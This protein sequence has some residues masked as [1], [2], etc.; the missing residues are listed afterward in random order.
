MLNRN[1][2]KIWI[3][4]ISFIWLI[5]ILLSA[6]KRLAQFF[7]PAGSVL[8][9]DAQQTYLPAARG[10]LAAPWHFLTKDQLSYNV[11][12]LGY[13]WP[14]LWSADP[15]SN[16]IAN[17][18]LFL[19]CVFLM[20]Y[21]G[22][23]LAGWVAGMASSYL[24][25]FHPTIVYY[26]PHVLTES[27]YLF[28]LLVLITSAIEYAL[29]PRLRKVCAGFL[30]FGLTVTLLTRPILQFFTVG[31]LALLI[32]AGIYWKYAA[33]TADI[34]KIT[35][36]RQLSTALIMA[37]ALP[38]LVIIKNGT[39][40]N[41]W[42]IGTGAGT[43]IYYGVSPLKAGLEPVFSGFAYDAGAIAGTVAPQTKGNPLAL[44]SDQINRRVALEIIK[45]TE[46]S[47]NI[48]FFGYK[49]KSWLLYSTPELLGEPGLRPFRIFEWITILTATFIFIKHRIKQRRE[50]EIQSTDDNNTS[51][52]LLFFPLLLMPF[53][54]AVQLTPILYNDRY[55]L[56]SMEPW[57]ILACGVSLGII[58][59]PNWSIQEN[60]YSNIRWVVSRIAIIGLL[61]TL[62]PAITKY[63]IR[64][65]EWGMDP[66]RPGPTSV[67]FNNARFG[68]MTAV[69]ATQASEDTWV[70]EESPAKL[71]I[72]LPSHNY[73]T[74]S[75]YMVLDMLWRMRFSL[76][77][78]PDASN[79][80]KKVNISLT[81]A[82]Q[83]RPG[84]R[85]S[86]EIDTKPDGALHTYAIFGNHQLRPAGEGF[87]EATFNCPKGSKV[88]WSAIELLQNTMPQAADAF[89]KHGT[90][91]NVYRRENPQ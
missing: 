38:I 61:I 53:A 69:G 74:L 11:A 33:K 51:R 15:I 3:P 50:T 36:C 4:F 82:H 83:V 77:P 26:A 65:E 48:R 85:T 58:F 20:W 17:C 9:G 63:S 2:K 60:P 45:N 55:N 88:T 52:A 8:N 21:C 90:P 47:D 89:I 91:I 12:P 49:L 28:G 16:Q 25:V 81:N 42:S 7:P 87:L 22:Y 62:P 18:A 67:I 39:Y 66:H 6:Q 80:C 56:Y 78:A 30:A 59:N 76:T 24:L 29:T 37:L 14:A 75:H 41:V 35:I 43:G 72:P 44:E 40:F 5:W 23:R 46:F 73:D 32:F 70:L 27:L 10:L 84:F 13:L 86:T 34:K 1:I 31:I 71:R 19:A 79:S 54:M 57:I 68:T 64:H